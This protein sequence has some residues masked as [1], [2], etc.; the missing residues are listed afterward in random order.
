MVAF[1]HSEEIFYTTDKK[2]A[3]AANF[4]ILKKS[5][6]IIQGLDK[7]ALVDRGYLSRECQADSSFDDDARIAQN[8]MPRVHLT[9]R[10]VNVR[11]ED[12]FL[13]DVETELIFLKS[14]STVESNGFGPM[15]M[16]I[17]EDKDG[18]NMK[19]FVDI[20]QFKGDGDIA[21]EETLGLDNIRPISTWFNMKTPPKPEEKKDPVNPNS[22]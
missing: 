14:D 8:C 5:P 10:Y 20:V 17:P 19:R 16:I 1:R 12:K 7:K 2:S 18:I 9:D 21:M 13:V 11:K 6:F 3:D 15:Y 4:M 22:K